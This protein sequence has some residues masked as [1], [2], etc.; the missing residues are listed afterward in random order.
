[1]K[2]KTLTL[3]L[4]ILLMAGC[5]MPEQN[6]SAMDEN[7]VLSRIDDKVKT[8]V[9]NTLKEKYG[10]EASFRIERGVA[11]AADFW[12][13]KDGTA[14]EFKA[15]CEAQFIA[16]PEELDKVFNRLSDDFEALLG[17]YNKLTVKLKMPIHMSNYEL[18]GV[19]EVLGGYDPGAHF[20]DDMFGNKVA[21]IIL[22]NFPF[23]SLNE[24]MEKGM[25]WTS[26]Q[27]AYARMGELFTSRTPAEM[28][29]NKEKVLTDADNYI[30]NYNIK[31]GKL[32]TDDGRQ[33]FP[34]DLSLISHWGIR[35]ELKSRY[36]DPD[37]LEKQR[38]IYQVMLRIINQDIPE[39]VINNAEVEWDPF[40]NEVK[41][42]EKTIEAAPEG[43]ERYAVLLRNFHALKQMDPY[44]PFYPTYISRK[45]DEDME[46]PQEEVEKLFVELVSSPELKEVGQLI[47]SRL[48]RPLEPFDIWYD[49][50]KTRSNISEEDL[51][52]ITRSKYPTFNEFQADL[53]NIL[54]KLG[55]TPEKANFIA[56]KVTV[57]PARGS[58]HAWGAAMKED[59]AHLRTRIGEN[60]M[61]YKGYNIAVHE[62]GHNVE[63]TIS[64]HDVDFYMIN[65]VPNTAFTEALAFL[66]QKRDLELLGI[67]TDDAMGHHLEALDN[68]WSNFEIMGVSL[69]DMRVWKW[70]YA[71]PEASAAELQTE[72]IRVAKEVWN[73]YYAPVFGVSDSPILAI[74]SHMIDNPLYLSAYP[75]GELI[76]FQVE[77]Y[78]KGKSFAS[79]VERMYSMGRLIPDVWMK[80]ATGKSISIE[81]ALNAA[82]EALNAMK[83]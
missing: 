62:F 6:K 66:F 65:G 43:G 76:Q 12:N 21:F 70:L 47:S 61:D 38:M 55:F 37:G 36:A 32:R 80:K 59:N 35:D 13:G 24:K 52:R 31:M 63:Q 56:S 72:V 29:L 1:M 11:Q 39:V 14:E 54:L 73:A 64:L 75:V 23:Y 53:P 28:V 69:V 40:S 48:G 74:Y 42:G 41:K 57:D 67:N 7:V 9:I 27:W 45:F 60:G 44:S 10:D 71:H 68:I 50:F 49:G 25:D 17:S 20:K 26:R 19:D 81:P 82:R 22:L 51:N 46:I 33:L 16:S 15:F 2:P 77:G 5:N 18:L 3:L 83:Q 30:S 78:M 4:A 8:E 34:D 58:G 79:E